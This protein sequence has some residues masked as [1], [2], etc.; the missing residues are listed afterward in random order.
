MRTKAGIALLCIVIGVV[1]I[2][3]FLNR[4]KPQPGNSGIPGGGDFAQGEPISLKGY[5]GGEKVN[6]LQDPDIMRVL[7]EK[8][9]LSLDASK[10]GSIEMV[11]SDVAGQDFLWP[12]ND[13]A[14]NI[15]KQKTPSASSDT[16]LNSPIVIY[17]W[18][19]VTEALIK[20]GIVKLEN[21]TYY[22]VDFK[23]LITLINK[24]ASWQ[25]LGLPQLH[26]KALIYSTDPGKSSSGNLFAALLANSL[27]DD[28]PGNASKLKTA[29]PEIKRFFDKQGLMKESSK[30]L[31]DEFLS[32]GMGNKQLIIGYEAQLIEY[33]Q[34]NPD[35]MKSRQNVVQTLYPRPTVWSAHPLIPLTPNA[36][37][38]ASAL[39][40]SQIQ[41]IAWRKHGFRSGSGTNNDLKAI[42]SSGVPATIDNIV[43]IPSSSVMKQVQNAIDG[44]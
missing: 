8:Y 2:F 36:K 14:L 25:S 6:L 23:K 17:S 37:R 34:E 1:V 18:D 21:K 30:D 28:D 12:S 5:V 13:I 39:Q 41:E 22:V 31:F 43:Q 15:Y 33:N 9:G 29:L 24:E 3:S 27:T 7:K 38:L 10:R 11:E 19:K 42:N 44:K 4:N 20:Q 35:G 26:G 32:R 16:I 40:S